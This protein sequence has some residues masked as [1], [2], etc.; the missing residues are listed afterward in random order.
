MPSAALTGDNQIAASV[1]GVST[2]PVTLLTIQASSPATTANFYAATDG[3]DSWSG[4]LASSLAR[5]WLQVF[6]DTHAGR[7]IP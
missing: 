5:H 4:T 3:N 7:T 2:S 6:D 1:D